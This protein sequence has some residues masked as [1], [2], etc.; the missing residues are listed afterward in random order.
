M[1]GTKG[2]ASGET[3]GGSAWAPLGIPVFRALWIATLAS[4]IGTWMHDI[5]AGWLMT[6]LSSS[7]LMVAWVQTATSLPIFLL[8]L[9]AGALADIVDRR[10]HLILVQL[11]MVIV[12]G[13]L[14]LVTQ[15]GVITPWLLVGMTFAMGI[16]SAMLMP[17]WAAIVPELVPR[18][19]LP[20]AIALNSMGINVARAI[21]PALA[22]VIVS[23]AGSGAVF[24]LNAVSYLGVIW[25][26]TGWQRRPAVSQ[27]PAERML[28]AM[29]SG[30]R[31]ARHAPALQAAAIR[32]V[33][34]ALFA[35]AA[36]A[37]LPLVAKRLPDGGPQSFGLLVAAVGAGAV[38]GALVLPRLRLRLSRNLLVTL[39]SLLYAGC[40][41]GLATLQ[42][43]PVLALVMALSGV[44]WLTVL[45]SLQVTAQLALPNWVRSRGLAL[46]MCV[47]MGSMALG[48]LVWGKL[49]EL[50]SLSQSLT[51]ASVGALLSVILTRRWHLGGMEE[52]DLS[53]SMHWPSAPSNDA[54]SHDAGPVLVTIEYELPPDRVP[55]FQALVAALGKLR[56]Q[57]GAFSWGLYQDAESPGHFIESFN[58]DSWLAHLRQ[59]ERVTGDMRALQQQILGLLLPGSKPVI[60]HYVAPKLKNPR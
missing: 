24:A 2:Q 46:F 15:L 40:L 27:L 29:R 26:L 34:F 8:A 17:A 16:G 35:S 55:E 31:F 57:N 53:P 6:Q 32:G 39:A 7:A 45:S 38:C 10:R 1:A 5:G 25:V 21:G 51:L 14:A 49:A 33:G 44:A 12:T 60:S 13:S 20:S 36:W 52:L 4:N 59:H 58:D 48:S 11:F 43:L 54:L 42:H 50:L 37:L 41:Y 28:G 23:F 56:R 22:G 47:F 18:E 19:A 9:P 30:L 3:A